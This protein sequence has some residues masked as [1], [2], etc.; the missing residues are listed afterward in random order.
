MLGIISA[1]K[2]RLKKCRWNANY[3]FL[4]KFKKTISLNPKIFVN[5]FVHLKIHNYK[6]YICILKVYFTKKY[7][8][9]WESQ[10]WTWKSLVTF[11]NILIINFQTKHRLKRLKVSFIYDVATI[12]YCYCCY[13]YDAKGFFS[14][15]TCM[16]VEEF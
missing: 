9:K 14:K 2:I 10:S 4:Y 15:S 6:I 12:F 8:N 13:L 7:K 3:F 11:R 16:V 1:L 5:K